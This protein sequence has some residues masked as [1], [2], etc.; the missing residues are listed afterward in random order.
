M[1][2]IIINFRPQKKCWTAFQT[3]Y[4]YIFF[5][6]VPDQLQD[7]SEYFGSVR[8]SFGSVWFRFEGK[9]TVRFR[10]DTLQGMTTACTC[11]SFTGK[12]FN[13][14]AFNDTSM[15]I[16]I[17]RQHNAPMK[18]FQDIVLMHSRD[19]CDLQDLLP[20]VA[21]LVN[22]TRDIVTSERSF[23]CF[24]RIKTYMRSTLGQSHR[25]SPWANTARLQNKS[26]CNR[27]PFDPKINCVKKPF[28]LWHSLHF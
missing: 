4:R 20:E 23:L 1:I 26:Q 6:F 5:G 22:C 18:T 9:I 15:L 2:I 11:R 13:L 19:K 10:F 14:N 25:T 12:I 7:G 16:D 21:K 17:A 8:F 24:H 27:R 3:G 28:W